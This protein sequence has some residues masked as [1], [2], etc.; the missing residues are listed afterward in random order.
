MSTEV[1]R[2]YMK[3]FSLRHN[4]DLGRNELQKRKSGT[5]VVHDLVSDNNNNNNNN[6]SNNNNNGPWP[7]VTKVA[8]ISVLKLKGF[9]YPCHAMAKDKGQRPVHNIV[10][11]AIL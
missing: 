3:T 9:S 11:V 8:I 4:F 1:A 10:Q 5:H 6:N 7:N 2:M